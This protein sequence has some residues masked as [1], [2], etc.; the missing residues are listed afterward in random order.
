VPVAEE[1]VGGTH[2]AEGLRAEAAE[3]VA[4]ELARKCDLMKQKYLGYILL[5]KHRKIE[6]NI[7]LK[8]T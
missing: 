7:Y 8:T 3:E 2:A 5:K 1:L 4:A 6:N